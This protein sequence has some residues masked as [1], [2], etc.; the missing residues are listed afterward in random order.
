MLSRHHSYSLLLLDMD[1]G[2]PCGETRKDRCFLHHFVENV[3]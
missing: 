2:W 3:M 1:G